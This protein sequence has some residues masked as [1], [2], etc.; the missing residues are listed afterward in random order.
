MHKYF[1]YT[2]YTLVHIQA[3]P[4]KGTATCYGLLISIYAQSQSWYHNS[5]LRIYINEHMV[6][7]CILLVH[8][9]IVLDQ[10][11]E[12]WNLSMAQVDQPE[13][14]DFVLD[15]DIQQYMDIAFCSLLVYDICKYSTRIHHFT[16]SYLLK[17]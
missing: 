12:Y 6:E 2:F 13:E 5:Q 17:D 10:Q 7:A 9:L 14:Y 15:S 11:T 4:V 16:I 8:T 3:S 1:V